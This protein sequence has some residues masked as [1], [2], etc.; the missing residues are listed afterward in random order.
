MQ[1]EGSRCR[2]GDAVLPLRHGGGRSPGAGVRAGCRS[3]CVGCVTKSPIRLPELVSGS[4]LEGRGTVPQDV[5]PDGSAVLELST[6]TSG[7]LPYLRVAGQL[8]RHRGNEALHRG[9]GGDRFLGTG[10]EEHPGLARTRGS[11]GAPGPRRRGRLRASSGRWRRSRKGVR[12]ILRDRVARLVLS[13]RIHCKPPRS[14]TL[15]GGGRVPRSRLASRRPVPRE[16]QGR[17]VA[18]ARASVP[19]PSAAR[20]S[21]PNGESEL[22]LEES[23]A[24]REASW[25]RAPAG[26]MPGATA[27]SAAAES[28]RARAGRS[29]GALAS[30]RP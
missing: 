7:G 22:L 18:I 25:A 10:T 29:G 4:V 27:Q 13:P 5:F 30:A 2:V 11:G 26:L 6:A 16:A 1:L 19:A 14:R 17:Q 23:A 3:R 20:A 8:A 28:R 12:A 24:G 21:S 15:P 9:E